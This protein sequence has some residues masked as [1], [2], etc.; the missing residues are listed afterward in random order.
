MQLRPRSPRTVGELRIRPRASVGE[1]RSCP[2]HLRRA[3]RFACVIVCTGATSILLAGCVRVNP[4]PDY[5]RAAD[6][7]QERVG[8]EQSYHPD[9]AEAEIDQRVDALLADGL[10]ADEAVQV[11]LLNNRRFQALFEDI[12]VSRAEVVQSGLLSNPTLGLSLRLPEGGGLANLTAGFAQQIAD[13]WQIPVRKRIAEK[14]LEQTILTVAADGV[15]LATETRVRFYRLLAL[16]QI[17]QI[18]EDNVNLAERSATL[19]QSRFAAGEVGRLDVNLARANLLDVRREL[20][21]TRR[22]RELARDE[23]AHVLGLSRSDRN[24]NVGGRL[25]DDRA[26]EEEDGALLETAMG[27]RLD[28]RLAALRVETAE[29]ELRKQVLAAFPDVTLGFEVERPERRALPG[30]HVL[31]DTARASVA[32]G[33]LTAPDIQSRGERRIERSQIID[34]LLGPTLDITLPVW[35][36]N[37]AQIARAEYEVRQRRKEYEDLLDRVAL[38]L[39]RALTSIRAAQE[40]VTLARDQTL[41]LAEENV[42]AARQ[43]Y[44]AGEQ[45]VVALI[46]AQKALVAQR[47]QY[48]ELQRDYA[49]AAAEL[50][51]ALGGESNDTTD[52]HSADE[53]PGE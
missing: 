2:T 41:P 31:A 45:D 4:G 24:W 12:G 42:E 37:Q 13:L 34:T 5:Q 29:Q 3:G 49:V 19:T 8:V 28:A 30:R 52:S 32:N 7:I 44:Q 17:E 46:E 48:V 27:R 14:Q 40:L 22:D 39:S 18:T 51:Q 9:S 33:Q 53:P 21:L 1:T 15:R 11:A 6:L 38:G 10:T 47:R 36:Q 16:Q 50:R 20:L 25:V 35:H 23:L 26:P 43:A